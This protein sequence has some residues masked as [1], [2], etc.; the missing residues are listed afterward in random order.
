[1]VCCPRITWKQTVGGD[2]TMREDAMIEETTPKKKG[3]STLAWIGIGCGALVVI[4]AVAMVVIGLFLFKKAKDVAGGL[5]EQPRD[6][7]RAADREG[8]PG[9]RG[10]VRG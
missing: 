7:G 4:V 10:G 5:Q 9:A 2:E 1:M 6:G 3:L 8:E